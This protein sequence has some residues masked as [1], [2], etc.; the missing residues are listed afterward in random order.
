VEENS[1]VIALLEEKVVNLLNQF[2]EARLSLE[3]T[4]QLAEDLKG[5]NEI[6]QNTL[7]SLKE[8]NK[9]LKVANN[10]L[11]SKEGKTITRNKINSLIREVDS[12]INQ[13]TDIY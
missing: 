10:L 4:K 2:K 8:E 3:Q 13:L 12:C 1:N 5:E 9:S 6:L 7:T 11:G